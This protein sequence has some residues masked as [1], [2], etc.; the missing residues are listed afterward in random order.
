MTKKM[1]KASRSAVKTLTLVKSRDI[2]VDKLLKPC[3]EGNHSKC[4]GWAV[5]RREVSP[6]DANYFLKCTCA[7]HH[8]KKKERKKVVRKQQH[9]QIRK[10]LL[11]KK[12]KKK[13]KKKQQK[14]VVARK[15]KRSKKARRR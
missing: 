5:L 2:V 14:A 1:A 11:K 8:Q 10:K 3:E 7:C 13:A 6:I 4:T 9:Q 12:I 15:S